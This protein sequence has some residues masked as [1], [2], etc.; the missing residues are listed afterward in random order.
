MLPGLSCLHPMLGS[1]TAV[2]SDSVTPG[3]VVGQAPVHGML[4]G[5]V[6]GWVAVPSCRGSS[7]PR[8]ELA[9]LMC[10][11]L[12]GRFFTTGFTWEAHSLHI[13]SAVS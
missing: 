9:F 7:R 10:P 12:A 4:Q 8:I 1:A 6:L 2:V 13:K 3:V 5:R 11:A